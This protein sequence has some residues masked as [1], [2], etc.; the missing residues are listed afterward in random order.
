MYKHGKCLHIPFLANLNFM[1]Q[2]IQSVYLLAVAALSTLLLKLPLADLMSAKASFLFY[3]IG[4]ND[5]ATGASV[6]STLPIF[7]LLVAT[8]LVSIITI[9]QFKRRTIQIR[10]AIANGVLILGFYGLFF[11][12]YWLMKDQLMVTLSLRLVFVIPIISFIMNWLAIRGIKAD[13]ALVK[14]LDRIR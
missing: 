5:V 8:I 9:F 11:M 1:I 10:L 14:S 12:Y 7:L 6:Y 3:A 4:V 2:R 13:E